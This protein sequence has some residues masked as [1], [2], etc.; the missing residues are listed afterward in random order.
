MLGYLPVLMTLELLEISLGISTRRNL[1][2]LF[3]AHQDAHYLQCLLR[4]DVQR[5][6]MSPY[7]KTQASG[8]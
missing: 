4:P 1:L 3:L 2:V 5:Y 7:T 6:T 8:Q